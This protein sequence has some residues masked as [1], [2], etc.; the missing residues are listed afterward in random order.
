[1]ARGRLAALAAGGLLLRRRPALRRTAPRGARVRLLAALARRAR[2]VR[3]LRR[4]LLRHALVLQG[5]VLLL[6][7]D[8]WSLARHGNPRF[9]WSRGSCPPRQALLTPYA[10]RIQA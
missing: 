4:A 5:L 8:A 6:V 1:L 3:D 7:L 10:G 9:G 2:R